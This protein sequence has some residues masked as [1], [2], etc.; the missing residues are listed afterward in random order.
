MACEVEEWI[1]SSAWWQISLSTVMS[2]WVHQ[3]RYMKLLKWEDCWFSVPRMSSE[4]CIFH[5]GR[6]CHADGVLR[7]IDFQYAFISKAKHSDKDCRK[8]LKSKFISVP[9]KDKGVCIDCWTGVPWL[10]QDINVMTLSVT[11]GTHLRKG[12]AYLKIVL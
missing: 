6:N 8:S 4:F 11:A 7:G 9:S 1:R 12:M 3:W 10:G 2:L 5:A